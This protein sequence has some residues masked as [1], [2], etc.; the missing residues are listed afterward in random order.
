MSRKYTRDETVNHM[1]AADEMYDA[2]KRA[3]RKLSS[4]GIEAVGLC[5]ESTEK[6]ITPAFQLL[7][8]VRAAL[9]LADAPFVQDE[10]AH[11]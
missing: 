1:Q 2:L 5:V 7:R 11:D 10:V 4:L 8:D 9:A 3:E 6:R